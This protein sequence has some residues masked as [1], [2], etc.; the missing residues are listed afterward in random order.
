MKAA[1]RA[2]RSTTPIKNRSRGVSRILVLASA[3]VVFSALWLGVSAAQACNTLVSCAQEEIQQQVDQTRQQAEDTANQK[4]GEIQQQIAPVQQQIDT[5]KQQAENTA[6]QKITETEQQAAEAQASDTYK[7]LIQGV[8]DNWRLPKSFTDGSSP[9]FAGPADCVR[10][11]NDGA[12]DGSNETKLL[13]G[14]PLSDGGAA[15]E[16]DASAG[17]PWLPMEGENPYSA[18]AACFGTLGFWP[19]SFNTPNFTIRYDDDGDGVLD[20]SVSTSNVFV[21]SVPMEGATGGHGRIQNAFGTRTINGL[22]SIVPSAD[23][24]ADC[25]YDSSRLFINGYVIIQARL[26]V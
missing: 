4:I 1:K 20:E 7:C 11:D 10:L 6:N 18:E 5:Q 9:T 26:L 24:P 22:V 23:G 12:V 21:G 14:D 19:P 2:G 3:T 17:L 16:F 25:P 15:F 13:G 8:A